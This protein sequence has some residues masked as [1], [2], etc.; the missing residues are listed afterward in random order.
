MNRVF[1][2]SHAELECLT[3]GDIPVDYGNGYDEFEVVEEGRVW[4]FFLYHNNPEV[5]VVELTKG[6]FQRPFWVLGELKISVGM[7]RLK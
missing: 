6:E 5:T 3:K 7:Q 4:K 1:L 2:A